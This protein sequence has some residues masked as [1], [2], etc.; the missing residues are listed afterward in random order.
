MEKNYL[1]ENEK[2]INVKQIKW[3]KVNIS[4]VK[5]KKSR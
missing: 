3:L 2:K 4:I 5:D 1:N